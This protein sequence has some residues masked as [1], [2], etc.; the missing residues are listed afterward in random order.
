MAGFRVEGN[1]SGN[2]A[3]VTANNELTVALGKVAGT[4][5]YALIFGENDP[6][7]VVG[8]PLIRSG[9]VTADY[10]QRV[11]LDTL[12]LT[13]TFN[14]AAQNSGQWAHIL[15]TMTITNSAAGA[16]LNASNITTVSTGAMLKSYKRFPVFGAGTLYGECTMLNTVTPVTNQV[17]EVG[18]FDVAAATTATPLDGVFFRIADGIMTGVL[19]NNASE[20]TTGTLSL[21]SIATMHKYCISLSE[22]T[23]EFWID[24]V[25][26]ATINTP[27]GNAQPLASGSSPFAVRVYNKAVAPATAQQVRVG[28]I[29]VSLGDW[30]T[31]KPWPHQMAA[32][33]FNAVQGVGGMTQGQTAN[34]ANSA[35]PASATLSNTAAGYTTLGGQ[36]QFAAVAGAETD[37]A[38]FGYQVPAATAAV[39]G[40]VLHITGV[41]IAT[42]N[43]GA[44]SATTPTLLQWSLGVGATA[45]SL[46]TAEG[47]AAKAPRRFTIGAQSIPVGTAVGGSVADIET[48]LQTPLCA[49]AGEFVH[50][51]LKMPVGTATASQIIRGTVQIEGYWT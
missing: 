29:T 16:L 18:F 43:M 30:L 2:V 41:R 6:G 21:P 15:T 44:A 51:I 35:A 9:E 46:A 45:V 10:R 39:T 11:G 19:N 17:I 37:Y 38:L 48:R 28:D 22:R 23:V 25:L 7:T 24:D 47:A 8:S 1:T 13:D 32:M 49:N 42:W 27:A 14:Y 3:E 33:G 20:H 34:Y 40:R 26:Q 36:F 5:G 31:T 12:L 4:A 50:V